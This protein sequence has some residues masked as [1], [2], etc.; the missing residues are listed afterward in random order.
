MSC[1]YFFN[2]YIY[3]NRKSNSIYC[4][5][6]V[7]LIFVLSVSLPGTW[8]LAV[9]SVRKSVVFKGTENV[10]GLWGEKSKGSQTNQFPFLPSR[11]MGT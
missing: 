8:A 9:F 7:L 2:I 3:T 11:D 1:T 4:V 10:L 5:V 6:Q